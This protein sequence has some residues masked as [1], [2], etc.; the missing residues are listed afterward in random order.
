MISRVF[1]ECV[2]TCLCF[3]LQMD[4]SLSGSH[5]SGIRL[6]FSV[7]KWYHGPGARRTTTSP[8]QPPVTDPGS[9]A[10][11]SGR[12]PDRLFGT[13]CMCRTLKSWIPSL[14][15]YFP[16]SG[17]NRCSAAPPEVA[18]CRHSCGSKVKS[19]DARVCV[20]VWK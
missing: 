2:A 4:R 3:S 11:S 10:V 12:T 6:G 1:R 19:G 15:I 16:T 13:Y 17:G 8:P 20:C 18:V 5:D 14:Q 7:V 9:G